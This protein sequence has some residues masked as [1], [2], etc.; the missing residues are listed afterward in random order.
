[1]MQKQETDKTSHVFERVRFDLMTSIDLD[2]KKVGEWMEWLSRFGATT[3]GGVTRL[4]YDENW[5][6]AQLSLMEK[7]RTIGL[8]TYFDGV[9]NLFGKWNGSETEQKAILT[10]SHV[11]TVIDGGKYDGAFGVIAS[12]IALDYLKNNFGKP[13]KTIEVVSLCEEEGSRF[14]L[15][16]WGSASIIGKYTEKD[17]IGLYDQS[18]TSLLDAMKSAGYPLTTKQVKRDD[19]ECF[20]EI[21]VEQGAVLEIEKKSVGLVSHIVGQRR[22]N[23]TIKGESNHAGTTPMHYRKDSMHIASECIAYA[24]NEVSQ[25]DQQL[26]ATVGKMSV[27]PNVPNVIAKE[28]CFTLDVRHYKEELLDVYCEKV[29]SFFQNRCDKEGMDITMEKWVDVKPVSMHPILMDVAEEVVKELSIPYKH[30]ISGAGHDA[31]I[32]GSYCPTA[33]LFVPSVQGISHSPKEFTDLEDLKKGIIVLI[34]FLYKLA[35]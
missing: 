19:I 21:H 30:M 33:L 12:L 20:I 4:L 10:G 3:N 17:A 29:F 9:G 6:E 7:M 18:G 34:H 23:I 15:A 32:F 31:Q 27:V 11:D 14:P 1:M 35:Y 28:V 16:F 24:M 25:L 13:K 26:V 5:K 22:Y 2:A 8:E